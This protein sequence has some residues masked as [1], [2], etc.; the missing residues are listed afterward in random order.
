MPHMA[1]LAFMG[2]KMHDPRIRNEPEKVFRGSFE[3]TNIKNNGRYRFTQI[4]TEESNFQIIYPD[5]PKEISSEVIECAK[6][7]LMNLKKLNELAEANT[8]SDSNFRLH[9]IKP[10]PIEVEL[11]YVSDLCNASHGVFFKPDGSGNWVYDDW[12]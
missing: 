4:V 12:G 1:A 11:H 2:D 10:N 9:Y 7:V 6:S 8:P 3:K 5:E